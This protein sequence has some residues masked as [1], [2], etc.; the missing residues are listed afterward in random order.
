MQHQ[1]LQPEVKNRKRKKKKQKK[2][3]VKARE[4]S[5]KEPTEGS[6]A[7]LERQRGA[8]KA[9]EEDTAGKRYK[10]TKIVVC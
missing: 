9:V 2:K 5:N 10:E 8:A 1:E 6:V 4:A 3:R 7:R